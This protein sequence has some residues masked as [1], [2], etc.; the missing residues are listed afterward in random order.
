MKIANAKIIHKAASFLLRF[1]SYFGLISLPEKFQYCMF[2][3]SIPVG[4]VLFVFQMALWSCKQVELPQEVATA[5]ASLPEEIDFNR[6]VKRILSDKCFACHGPDAQKQK[7]D[8]RLDIPEAAYAKVTESGLKA[9]KPGNLRRS[10]VIHRILSNDPEYRMPTPESHL[11]LTEQEKAILIKWIEQGAEYKPHWAFVAPEKKMPPRVSNKSWVR[12]PIDNFVLAQQEQRSLKPSPEADRETLIR[13]LSFD[14]RG[15]SPT[16]MEVEE[17]L[18]D[19]DPAAYERLVDRMLASKHYG[20][21][22]SAYWLDVAR[23]ADS[24]GYLDDKHREMSPWR[25][26]VISA[27]NRNL[28]FDRFVT[29]QLAGDLL[30]NATQ[31]QVLATG[32]N[33]NHKQNSEAGI[34]EEEFRVEYVT[35]R[36]NTLGTAL[37]GLTLG[38]AKCHDHKY[39]PVSQKDYY[40]LFAFFNST[41]EK[42]GPNYGDEKVVPGP[43][44]L[45]TSPE[46][47]LSISRLQSRISQLE[48]Q[49]RQRL[50]AKEKRL[51]EAG[52]QE[53]SKSL[54]SSVKAKLDFD[55]VRQQKEQAGK[56]VDQVNPA[57]EANFK[58]AEFST[59]VNGNALKY[60]VLTRVVYPAT[61]VGYFERY[62]PFSVSLWVKVPEQYPL[63]TIFYSSENHRYGYQGYDLLLRDNRINFRLSHS[64]PH[65]AISVISREKIPINQWNHITV[66]YDGSSKASGTAVYLNGRRLEVEIEYDRLLKNIRQHYSI[67]KGPLIGLSFGEK[68]LDKSM[69]G[70]EVDEFHVFSDVL[71]VPEVNY[72]FHQ[73]KFSLRNSIAPDTLSPLYLGRKEL[74]AIYDSVQEVMVMGD[75]PKP[76]KTFLLQRGVYDKYGDEVQ[77]GTP[78]AIFK[79]DSKLPK[80]RLGLAKW[81]FDPKH[82][83]TS[84]VAVNRVWQ[85]IFGRGLVNSSDDFGNQGSLPTHPELLDHLAVWYRDNGWDTKALIKYICM[86]ATYRQSA[87]ATPE[88]KQ[89]DPDNTWLTRSPRYRYPA[90]ML[91]DNALQVS[92]LLSDKVGGASVYPYQPA[93][94][95][96]ELSDKV[97]RYQYIESTGEDL[98]RKSIYTVRKRTSV[99]PFL[100]IFDAPDRSVCTVKRQ[101]SSSPMQSLALLNDPQMVEAARLVAA[102][103]IREGGATPET[104]IRYGFRLITGSQPSPKEC[105]MAMMM[106]KEEEA[107]YRQQSSKR[108]ALLSIGAGKVEGIDELQLTAYSNLALA[109]M[110]TD[111]FLTRK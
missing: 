29:W 23:Y 41:F 104:R 69:P 8:L 3:I 43:T 64:F 106:L 5:Y 88:T 32:F 75:L 100:H 66:S 10:E 30:P 7:A 39:D 56:F 35:D 67:H 101:V 97:W 48:K 86:S 57:I 73:K 105:A 26:W 28:P 82:P 40:S 76:R 65:D 37:L 6:D 24:H 49:D 63:A 19:K 33:R 51:R 92:G 4:F 18:S 25:D 12:N 11:S 89:N 42:G 111:A 70:G 17:F 59:G 85:L 87:V 61:Q 50:A 9:I 108:K 52:D 107:A 55:H 46:Q 45:L 91:R 80:N 74:C 53:V 78:A 83:L 72:L 14:I 16:L 71:T 20:E 34:I 54:A 95:W 98:Y 31:E 68:V 77:P 22:M 93:G 94:L 38:C 60:N 13:R 96:E 21:R 99:V 44:L 81:L 27:Y 58:K 109:L 36:T 15:I 110:N 2:R 47:D 90:E 84:R 79:Y 1:R 62:E 102:R 103:M